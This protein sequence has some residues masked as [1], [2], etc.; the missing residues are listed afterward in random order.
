M[1][2]KI[3]TRYD[4]LFIGGQWVAPSSDAKVNIVSP[5]DQ[6]IT[7]YTVLADKADIDNAV[8]IAR[9]T[10]DSGIWS[11]K[12]PE[13]R[14]EVIARFNEIHKEYA[15]EF[16]SLITAENGSNIS[17]T[18]MLQQSLQEQTNA[19]L[20]AAKDF[21]WEAKKQTAMGGNVLVRR[22]P[23]GVVAAIIPWNAPQQSALVKLIPALLAGCTV[24]FKP[25][26]ETALDGIALG[27]LFKEAGLPDG[28]LSI[29]PADREVSEYLVGKPEI[30]KI[31]FTG[32]TRAGK[33]IAATAAGDM[34]RFSLELGGKSAA[35]VLEDADISVVVPSMIYQGFGNNGQACIG[36]TRLL[37]A[38]SRYEEITN[39]LATAIGTMKVGNPQNAE[40]FLGPV[41]NKTQFEKV[42]GYIETG[43]E[44]GAKILVG[45][46]G[47]PTG[48]ELDNGWYIKPTLFVDVNNNM[49][50]A[51]EEI[52]GPVVVAIPFETEE[53]AIQIANDNEYGLNGGVFTANIEKGL[54][55]A[56]KIRTG[57]VVVNGGMPDYSVP[58]G[59]YK[60]SGVG[61]E[62]GEYGL[63]SFTEYKSIGY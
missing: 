40:N 2:T 45:G 58:F 55:I 30:D 5:H 62:F 36:L 56:R 26:P 51:R 18:F 41:F 24:I 7:G 17:F 39:A 14:Q 61:R 11:E 46:K 34:K 6:S 23:V 37:V 60:K 35:I 20:R 49:R 25:T 57:G 1:K 44:E 22:E 13:E 43:L 59:G 31:A 4:K 42:N 28:V 3:E 48:K 9:K 27:E 63:A 47:K 50:I 16:A 54:A 15:Q 21:Q 53:E 8:A 52:F 32:S 38:K 10:F 12:T 19:Y 33:S 29:L